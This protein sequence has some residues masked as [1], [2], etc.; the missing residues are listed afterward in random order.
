MQGCLHLEKL[1][2][3]ID[4]NDGRDRCDAQAS[5]P[6]H[7]NYS[8]TLFQR[9]SLPCFH[10]ILWP[11]RRDS[12]IRIINLRKYIQGHFE[13]GL[14]CPAYQS[15]PFTDCLLLRTTSGTS[16]KRAWITCV[17]HIHRWKSMSIVSVISRPPLTCAPHTVHRNGLTELWQGLY[18]PFP[19]FPL[20]LGDSE[21][22]S[23]ERGRHLP[24]SLGRVLR[25]GSPVIERRQGPLN[26]CQNRQLAPM[27]KLSLLSVLTIS[28]KTISKKS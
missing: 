6:S 10:S 8:G 13:S 11:K 3:L 15:R 2:Y 12:T 24:I 20:L 1:I 18:F 26:G 16:P 17:P 28:K 21:V 9:L 22:F 4:W 5:M 23:A 19:L 25:L 14:L 7:Q 27:T